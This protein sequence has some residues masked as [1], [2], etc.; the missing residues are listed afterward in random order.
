MLFRGSGS[1]VFLGD[2]AGRLFYNVICW[3]NEVRTG[4]NKRVPTR[5]S[6]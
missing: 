5:Q 1:S 2:A 3:R 6:S 4:I